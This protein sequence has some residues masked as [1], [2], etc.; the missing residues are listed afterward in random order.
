MGWRWDWFWSI[1]WSAFIHAVTFQWTALQ[2]DGANLREW[3]RSLWDEI[4]RRLD[5]LKGWAE[6]RISWLKGY[7]FGLF[8]Q[9][10]MDAARWV[11]D[12]RTSLTRWIN[13]IITWFNDTRNWL[14][15]LAYRLKDEAIGWARGKADAVQTWARGY[16]DALIAWAV[17]VYQWLQP[18]RDLLSSWLP[19]VR[20]AI[21]WL[22]NYAWGHLQAFLA[23]PLGYV[24]GW[25]LDPIVNLVN[26]WS[27][28]GPGLRDFVVQDLPS[29]RNLLA[30]GLSFLLNLVDHPMDVILEA[31]APV[32]IDWLAHLIE[33]NW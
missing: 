25:L 10:S 27:A 29:L 17:S 5:D 23:N 13:D 9:L 11:A 30:R 2:Q 14:V 8:Y 20:G 26:W 16:I 7:G 6:G 12:L 22:K 32:F 1:L 18:L 33:E 15:D 4:A 3:W 31:I 24:L 19:W 28:W 21:D